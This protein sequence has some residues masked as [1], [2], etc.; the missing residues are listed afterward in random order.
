MNWFKESCSNCESAWTGG[1][2][3][4]EYRRFCLF[5]GDASG[6]MW[7]LPRRV[8][9]LVIRWRLFQDRRR[10]RRQP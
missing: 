2:P 6:T 8:R 4:P 1:H 3:N 10:R 7:R 5:C 9:R